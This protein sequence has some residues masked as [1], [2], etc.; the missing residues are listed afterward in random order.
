[1]VIKTYEV[2]I[3]GMYDGHVESGGYLSDAQQF[4]AA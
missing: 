4:E 2:I 1:V 3:A